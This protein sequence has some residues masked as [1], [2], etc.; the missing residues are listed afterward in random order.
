MVQNLILMVNKIKK[1][2]TNC[3]SISN[4]A[5]V[6]FEFKLGDGWSWTLGSLP[7]LKGVA[8]E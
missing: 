6:N 4:D 2:M 5:A 1:T 7:T 8:H 3:H